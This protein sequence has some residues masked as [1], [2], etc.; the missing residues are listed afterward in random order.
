MPSIIDQIVD[1]SFKIGETMTENVIVFQGE[2][3]V[4]EYGGRNC[5]AFKEWIEISFKLNGNVPSDIGFSNKR[6]LPVLSFMGSN[7]S[8]KTC[9]MRVLAFIKDFCFNSFRYSPDSDIPFDSFFGNNDESEFFILFCLPDSVDDEYTYELSLN[10][11]RVGSERL[12]KNEKLVFERKANE[13]A[14]DAFFNASTEV[15][16]RS[17]ASFFSTF[18][19]Y[20]IKAAE[21]FKALFEKIVTNVSYQGLFEGFPFDAPTYYHDNPIMLKRVVE[22]LKRFDTGIEYITIQDTYDPNGKSTFIP[23]FLFKTADGMKE[24]PF[25]AQSEGTKLLFSRLLDYFY[26][27]DNGGLLAVD[28]IDLHLHSNLVPMLIEYFNKPE[29]NPKQAQLVFTS[30]DSSL[31]DYLKKYSTYLF[32]KKNS[33]SY[34]YRIDEIPNNIRIRNDRPLEPSYKSGVFGGVPRIG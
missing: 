4:L 26:V 33:E 3:M 13:I 16:L 27:L 11:R 28:E 15:I 19:Q 8:G 22:E 23:L 34:C 7:A 9:A 14:F 25:M 1:F 31:I 24:L 32:E 5:W 21:P 18:F 2:K 20:G 30:H 6:V 10:T 29:N 17:N 12:S